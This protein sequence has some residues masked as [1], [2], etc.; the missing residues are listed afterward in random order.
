MRDISSFFSLQLYTVFRN[1][2]YAL[3]SDSSKSALK[4]AKGDPQK[5]IAKNFQKYEIVFIL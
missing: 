5:T 2:S 4:M 3:L 1:G